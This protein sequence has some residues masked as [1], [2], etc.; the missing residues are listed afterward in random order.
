MPN[1]FDVAAFIGADEQGTFY[2]DGS[3]RPT[4][5]KCGFYGMAECANPRR[6]N[7]IMNDVIYDNVVRM[8]KMGKQ[9]IIFAHK[10]AE[11]YTTAIEIM[12]MLKTKDFDE[13]QLFQS[14]NSW[15]SK[16]DV[17]RS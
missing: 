17:D 7:N 12:E 11:T 2:F 3:Y 9:V 6:L 4:P 1:Y 13:A 8:L 15:Q 10:R 14:E 16:R 5:L